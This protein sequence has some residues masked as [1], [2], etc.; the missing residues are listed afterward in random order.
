MPIHIS[1]LDRRRFLVTTGVG[2]VT[3]Q[4]SAVEAKDSSV[5]ESLVYI[6]ND[7]H[8]GE[9]HPTDSPVP[10][11]LRQAVNELLQLERKPAAVLINGDLALRDG[12][13]G[14][15]RH[16][17]EIIRPLQA[18]GINI[19]LTLGNHD[20][21][22]VFFE[23]LQDQQKE[24][25]PVKSRHISVIETRFANLFLLDSL[26]ETMVTQGTLGSEQLLWLGT[27][28]DQNRDK[29]AIVVT[30]HN[31]RL[32]GDPLH[33]PGGLIDSP[34]L[35]KVF[36]S[37]SHVK[38]YVHGHVHDRTIAEHEGVFILNT[39][40]TSYVADATKSTTGWT[41]AS[42]STTGV[43]LTTRTT[44]PQHAWNG[45]EKQLAWRAR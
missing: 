1:N 41:I 38:A 11:N 8:I 7:T 19:D 37:R 22:D 14:D 2:W 18:A 39:P 42:F 32:G 10:S 21:R 34:E 29:P 33:F 44:D 35:W 6:L 23:V 31:P 9:K 13:A 24:V 27:A 45:Q 4:C 12:Q 40:A 20:H 25:P 36:Q 15:Y 16:F 30:H 26:Q 3:A 5:D 43:T 17:M 28:L